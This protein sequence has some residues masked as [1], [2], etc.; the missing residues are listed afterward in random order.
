MNILLKR[1]NNWK[2]WLGQQPMAYKWFLWIVLLRPIIDVFWYVKQTSIISPLQVTGLLTLFYS[3]YYFIKL[4]S[5]ATKNI[6]SAFLVF[7]LL[8]FLNL[9]FLVIESKQADA[10][11]HFFRT[12]TPIVVFLYLTKIVNSRERFNG[13]LYTYLVSSIFPLIVLFYEIIF[14]PIR[15]VELNESRGGGFRLTGLYADLFNYMSFLI[16]NYL[17]LCYFFLKNLVL[18]KRN[19]GLAFVLITLF[20]VILGING[21]KHQ[22]SWTVFIMISGLTLLYSFK[23]QSVKKLVGIIVICLA[24]TAPIIYTSVFKPLFAKEIGA[25]KGEAEKDRMLNGRIIR[26][27]KYFELWNSE[28][29]YSKLFGVQFSEISYVNKRAMT[30]GGMHSDY[31]RFLFGSGIIGLISLLGFYL[32]MLRRKKYLLSFDAFFVITSVIIMLMYSISSN[33][34]G[35]SGVLMYLV[36][37]G[38]SY[39]LNYLTQKTGSTKIL[40][41]KKN[42]EPTTS[43][44]P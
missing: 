4:P 23:Y 3:F 37:V 16:G 33:P 35:S 9:F 2:K 14:S 38:L 43:T 42:N 17:I 1:F 10:I 19:T 32:A 7:S 18:G 28:N 25:Y 30:S 29:I 15:Y 44:N 20:L 27:E 12:I 13:F 24:F 36:M 22:A 5:R 8:L 31:V 40:Q 39:C 34:L 11:S 21:L 41:I 6:P 26:W